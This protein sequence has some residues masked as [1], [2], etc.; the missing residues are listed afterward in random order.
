MLVLK[1]TWLLLKLVVLGQRMQFHKE[2]AQHYVEQTRV[3]MVQ[4][5]HEN[6][7]YCVFKARKHNTKLNQLK[8]RALQLLTEANQVKIQLNQ[9]K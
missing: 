1:F 4:K 2:M 7:A 3:Y 9:G 8:K 5:N 6:K